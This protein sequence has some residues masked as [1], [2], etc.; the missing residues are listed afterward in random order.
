MTLTAEVFN[1]L[2]NYLKH[3]Y[4]PLAEISCLS[5]ESLFVFSWE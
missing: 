2:F 4:C 1:Q 5:A 3:S